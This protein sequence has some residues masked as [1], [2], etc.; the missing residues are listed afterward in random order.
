MKASTLLRIG[1]YIVGLW[2]L[3]SGMTSSIYYLHEWLSAPMTDFAGQSILG[4][5]V[6][7]HAVAPLMFGLFCFAFA[8]WITRVLLGRSADES[9]NSIPPLATRILVKV[10]SLYLL[11]IYG[12]SLLATLYELLALRSGNLTLSE[13]QVTSDLIANAIGVAFGFWLGVR[14]DRALGLLYRENI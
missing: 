2:S 4:S 8:G 7:G 6:F 9:V 12:P 3:L 11:G 1:I 5:M 13:V 10:L 14:T